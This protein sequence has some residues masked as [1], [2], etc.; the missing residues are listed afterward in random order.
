MRNQEKILVANWKTYLS[1]SAEIKEKLDIVLE[2]FKNVN[3]LVICPPS[4]Y[5]SQVKDMLKSSNIALGAQQVSMTDRDI[6]TGHVFSAMLKD[7]GC[8]YVIVGHSEVRELLHEDNTMVAKKST[9]AI[10]KNLQPIICVGES[11]EI[12]NSGDYIDFL[13]QQIIESLPENHH[14]SEFVIAYE[15]VWAIGTGKVPTNDEIHEVVEL[16]RGISNKN[17]LYGGSVNEENSKELA[18]IEG[19]GGFLV[20]G[21]SI[22]GNKLIKIF[23]NL[24]S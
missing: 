18:R 5:L 24:N 13:K 14:N 17:I 3:S 19:L 16:I 15:P 1:S 8:Q 20:G 7:I 11:R 21:A 23:H 12:R 6:A 2:E 22:Y 10:A 9:N 4:I